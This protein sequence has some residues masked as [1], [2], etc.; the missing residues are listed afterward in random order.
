MK[1][2]TIIF[3]LIAALVILVL[4]NNK[5]EASF[6]F[7]G[8]IRTSKLLILGIFFLLG[9]IMGGILFRR[10]RKQPNK[11]NELQDEEISGTGEATPDPYAHLSAEDRNFLGKND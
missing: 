10:K 2:K 3:G 1:P 9:V 11:I 8:E 5:E 7:F 4:F 6:W